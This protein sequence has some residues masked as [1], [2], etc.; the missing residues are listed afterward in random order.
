MPTPRV[1]HSPIYLSS[2]P[3]SG[4]TLLAAMLNNHKNIA[5]FNEPWIFHMLP[6]YGTLSKRLNAKML[7][8]DLARTAA[9]FGIKISVTLKT[10]VL[11]E[12]HQQSI[13]DPIEGIIVF[14]NHYAREMGK[15]RWGI[16][17]PRELAEIPKLLRYIPNLKIIHVVRDPRSTVALR[18]G[19]SN[20]SIQS[21]AQVY[22]FSYSWLNEMRL[23]NKACMLVDSNYFEVRYEDLIENPHRL[24]KNI[25][26]FLGEDFDP[27]ML[28]YYHRDNPYV[29]RDQQG[30]PRKTHH[31]VLQPVYTKDRDVW[32]HILTD[33]EVAVC[34]K[35]CLPEMLTRSYVPIGSPV[36]PNYTRDILVALLFRWNQFRYFLRDAVLERFFHETRK[37][38]ILIFTH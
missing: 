14:M 16:K 19:K 21:Y 26:E 7:V 29:P 6:K 33:Y 32:R 36:V 5:M 22:R 25:C 28:E 13:S 27:A 8:E 18:K 24:L 1:I 20:P 35:I 17:Q 34:E 4:A 11:E 31:D 15:P 23:A 12:I 9:S 10:R 30:K 37:L 2:I 38:F 3:R